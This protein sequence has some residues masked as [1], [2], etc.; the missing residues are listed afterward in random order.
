MEQIDG[1]LTILNN[2]TDSIERSKVLRRM[3][4]LLNEI[5]AISLAS[6][7]PEKQGI[8]SSSSQPH[9]SSAERT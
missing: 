6:S 4:I 7:K 2:T 9:D 1:Q 5:D 8:I 3:K